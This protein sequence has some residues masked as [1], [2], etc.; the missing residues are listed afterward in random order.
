MGHICLINLGFIL[1]LHTYPVQ[2]AV[3]ER[4]AVLLVDDGHTRVLFTAALR[5]YSLNY[6]SPFLFSPQDFG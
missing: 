3:I 4:E 5:R 1:D 2:A 6:V